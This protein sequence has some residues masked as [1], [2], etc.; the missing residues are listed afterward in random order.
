VRALILSSLIAVV[1]VVES[2]CGLGGPCGPLSGGRCTD[3]AGGGSGGGSDGGASKRAFVTSAT[4]SGDLKTAAGA[5]DGLAAGDALCETAARAQNLGGA[6]RAWL[7][8]GNTT[9]LSRIAD[10][11]PWKLIGGAIV[12]NNAAGLATT[13]SSALERD[14][15]G[16]LV[17][18]AD[19]VFTGTESGGNIV[20]GDCV[21]WTSA[22]AY[23]QA[24]FGYVGSTDSE[25]TSSRTG[26]TACSGS[27]HLFCLEQ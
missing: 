9:A 4:Y 7:S 18:S 21:G 19:Y 23:D 6:W 14:E 25:W 8:A 20:G 2:G 13:P 11:G 22:S 24:T 10:V 12:F 15:A 17:P 27:A 26:K 1:A 16:R 5:A 3:V